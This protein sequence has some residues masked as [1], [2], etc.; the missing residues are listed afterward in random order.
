MFLILFLE[1]EV[2]GR[3]GNLM[4]WV[5]LMRIVALELVH[6]DIMA[7]AAVVDLQ[8]NQIHPIQLMRIT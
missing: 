3:Y 2:I 7:V 5:V 4:F 6:K 1:L 8:G